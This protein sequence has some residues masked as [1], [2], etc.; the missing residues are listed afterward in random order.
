MKRREGFLLLLLLLSALFF[1]FFIYSRRC[2]AKTQPQILN[3][4]PDEDRAI[5]EWNWTNES[6]V[7]RGGVKTVL[8][9]PS[10]G[11]PFK[12]QK[13]PQPQ[14]FFHGENKEWLIF[15]I[16][17]FNIWAPGWRRVKNFLF[18]FFL[19]VCT[20]AHHLQ[21]DTKVGFCFVFLKDV[22]QRMVGFMKKCRSVWRLFFFFF[23]FLFG[24]LSFEDHLPSRS[25]RSQ[26]QAFLPVWEPRVIDF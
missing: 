15:R 26:P 18:L 3:K 11:F 19:F 24:C 4:S 2:L 21:P 16:K 8:I 7:G 14:V 12:I 1:Y 5:L 17:I 13:G 22:T 25:G 20:K 9:I 6:P 23:F 10:P